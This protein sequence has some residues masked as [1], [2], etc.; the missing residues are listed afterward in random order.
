MASESHYACISAMVPEDSDVS[1]DCSDS[2]PDARMP[3]MPEVDP[4]AQFDLSS[5]A[6][7]EML[8]LKTSFPRNEI[9]GTGNHIENELIERY[10]IEPLEHDAHYKDI[11]SSFVPLAGLDLAMPSRNDVLDSHLK[12]RVLR[13]SIQKEL[14]PIAELITARDFAQVM[15]DIVQAHHWLYSKAELIHGDINPNNIKARYE[16]GGVQG[17]LVHRDVP[18][19][20]DHTIRVQ[21]DTLIGRFAPEMMSGV[22]GGLGEELIS[23]PLEQVTRGSR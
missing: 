5:D 21:L 16:P 22:V 12:G 9:S 17:A 6:W 1:D 15:Y 8:V 10:N 11:Y 7:L 23:K 2:I 20:I 13:C 4:E 18:G 14:L 3:E 19:I